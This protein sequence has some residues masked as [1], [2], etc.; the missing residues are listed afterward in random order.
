MKL[1][2]DYFKFIEREMY[3]YD[4][5][6]KE[7]EELCEDIISGRPYELT[8]TISVGSIPGPTW[9][10]TE[11]L[12][13]NKVIIRMEKT[14]NAIDRALERL[15]EEHRKLFNLRYQKCCPWQEV[16]MELPV[17]RSNYFRM[18]KELVYAVAHEMGFWQ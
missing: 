8:T 7:L 5:Y 15:G 9:R 17:S 11:K 3:N 4:S 6:K 13:T 16:C 1:Q 14:I 10:K 2:R 12:L 18:R